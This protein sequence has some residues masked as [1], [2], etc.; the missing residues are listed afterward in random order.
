MS[1]IAVIIPALNEAGN[2]GQLVDEIWTANPD[3]IIVV[4]NGSTDDTAQAAALA[5]ANVISEPRRGYG[6]ACAAGAAAAQSAEI[7]VFIDGDGSFLPSELPLICN[8]FWKI[9]LIWY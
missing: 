8:P 1:R 6:Y 7:L 2:I 3:E 5:G 4:D 9:R